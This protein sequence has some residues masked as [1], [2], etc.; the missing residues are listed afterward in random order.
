VQLLLSDT[1][2]SPE[3]THKYWLKWHRQVSAS[4]ASIVQYKESCLSA[5]LSQ[6]TIPVS[7]L[8]P[9]LPLKHLTID[10]SHLSLDLSLPKS[11]T[12]LTLDIYKVPQIKIQ[13]L[14]KP[15]KVELRL[16]FLLSKT[17]IMS[18]ASVFQKMTHIMTEKPT[19]T[20]HSLPNIYSNHVSSI[21]PEIKTLGYSL[22]TKTSDRNG[23]SLEQTDALM[24]WLSP[25]TF[26]T[27]SFYHSV[28]LIYGKLEKI[29]F[30]KLTELDVSHAMLGAH[31]LTLLVQS[32]DPAIIQK[33][34]L[35]DNMSPKDT[36]VSLFGK[37]LADFLTHSSCQLVS[38]NLSNNYFGLGGLSLISNSLYR[39]KSVK[40]LYLVS[41]HLG[42]HFPQ[43]AD[44]IR[45]RPFHRLDLSHNDISSRTLI[46]TLPRMS[47]TQSQLIELRLNGLELSFPCVDLLSMN[48]NFSSLTHL[49]INGSQE[50]R[51]RDMGCYK[52]LKWVCQLKQL[53]VLSLCQQ[54]LGDLSM[55]HLEQV[56]PQW[57]CL[58]TLLMDDHTVTDRVLNQWMSLVRSTPLL[59]S[60]K[61]GQYLSKSWSGQ[62]FALKN[63]LI[64][65]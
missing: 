44:M 14:V 61:Q 29:S 33:L 19:K 55:E 40:E 43:L 32:L 1:V 30:M 2:L 21:R 3:K 46:E 8:S 24:Q 63:M 54:S 15:F 34:N 65:T 13:E 62:T 17:K 42:L 22:A 35:N 59:V 18:N 31:N 57:D 52:L 11:L 48:A 49:Y 60:L 26:K 4:P 37:T 45:T 47:S 27:L 16:Y 20:S 28:P 38:L 58:Q 36:Q 6:N 56:L 7:H 10:I 25:M 23:I 12:E 9:H 51:F 50:H 5:Y 64:W 41:C 53:H 39:N